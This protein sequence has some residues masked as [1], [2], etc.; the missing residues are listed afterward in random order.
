MHLEQSSATP[1]YTIT[2]LQQHHF[3]ASVLM[4]VLLDDE[5]LR[6]FVPDGESRGGKAEA[7]VAAAALSLKDCITIGAVDQSILLAAGFGLN[8]FNSTVTRS[9]NTPQN[10]TQRLARQV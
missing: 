8:L 7:S 10:H 5:Y 1:L 4:F 3:T 9:T 6:R 2:L